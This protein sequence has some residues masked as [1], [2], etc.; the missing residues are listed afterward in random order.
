MNCVPCTTLGTFQPKIFHCKV[1]CTPH[2]GT[3]C[4]LSLPLPCTCYPAFFT[5]KIVW[6]LSSPNCSERWKQIHTI[7]NG[8]SSK[9]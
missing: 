2:T 3:N 7:S 5:A 4:L 1:A 9:W 6:C 8:F